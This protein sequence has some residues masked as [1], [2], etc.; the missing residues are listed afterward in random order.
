MSK[1]NPLIADQKIDFKCECGR[2][3][4]IKFKDATKRNAKTTC[5]RCRTV[6][7]FDQDKSFKRELDKLNKSLDKLTKLF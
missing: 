3:I 4:S 2:K 1:I 6:I 5:P 7:H